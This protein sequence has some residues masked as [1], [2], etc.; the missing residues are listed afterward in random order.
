MS[1]ELY[2]TPTAGELVEAVREFLEGPVMAATE[3]STRYHARVAANALR[4]VE[5]QLQ[6]GPADVAAHRERL[7]DLG[8]ADDAEL[9]RAIR[10]GEVDDRYEAVKAAIADSVRAKL[11]VDNPRHL[12]ET[13]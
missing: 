1:A 3:G 2:D 7:A 4:I 12:E 11:R 5:R 13:S 9:A 6:H 10:A 8:F